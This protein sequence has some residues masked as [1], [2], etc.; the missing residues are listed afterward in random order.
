[1]SYE[2]FMAWRYLR[3]AEGSEEGQRFLRVITYLA[4]GG[5]TVGVAALLLALSTVRG[6]SQEIE[7]K[8]AGFGS[9]VQ[10]EHLRDQPLAG[11]DTLHRQLTEF[12]DVV[13]A[14]P[15]VEELILLRSPTS[16]EGAALVGMTDPSNY[17]T[18][19]I[20]RGKLSFA[21]DSTGLYGIVLGEG[22]ARLLGVDVGDLVTALSMQELPDA[23]SSSPGQALPQPNIKF[24]H[25]SGIYDTGLPQFDELYGFTAIAP[26]RDLLDYGPEEVSRFD[27]ILSDIGAADDVAAQVERDIGFPIMARSIYQVYRNLFA[28]INLQKSVIPMVIAVIIFVAAFNM[29]GTLL[30]VILEKTREIGIISSMGLSARRIKRLFLWLG[31]L[32]GVVG[33]I[34]GETLALVLALIQQQFGVIPVP[35]QAYYVETAPIALNGVDFLMVAVGT[36]V[37]CALAAYI[38]ARVAARMEPVRSIRLTT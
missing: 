15:I 7:Q 2:R 24:F 20:I 34:L 12:P 13:D 19:Q 18:G 36:V 37:L 26:A 16:I 22:L 17:L 23:M 9:H 5:V 3:G 14:K 11:A 38:P 21:P 10:V 25:V 29:M 4:V 1:M 33:T 27:L 8:V 28:W 31:V 6:F 35:E 30:I 32:I